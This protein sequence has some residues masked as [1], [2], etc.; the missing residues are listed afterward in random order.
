[1]ASFRNSSDRAQAWLNPVLFSTSSSFHR[2]SAPSQDEWQLQ[3]FHSKS[4]Q[5]LLWKYWNLLTMGLTCQLSFHC[6]IYASKEC[7]GKC[8]KL[9]FM[10]EPHLAQ[11]LGLGE[12]F[13]L[14]II[15][16]VRKHTLCWVRC[17][18]WIWQRFPGPSSNLVS[19]LGVSRQN[20]DRAQMF[21][22]VLLR[23]LI[24]P[25]G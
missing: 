12:C 6:E 10:S 3:G 23:L 16:R 2:G 19:L 24:L 20:P 4:I 18:G 15:N 5:N 22:V 13:V 21:W 7:L 14:P 25:A 8:F 11:P 1:M 9:P 17:P